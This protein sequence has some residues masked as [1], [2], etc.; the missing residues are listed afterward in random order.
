MN[1]EKFNEIIDEVFSQCKTLLTKKG[2]EY[3]GKEDRL[4][5]FKIA[6]TIKRETPLESLSGMMIKHTTKLYGKI[7]DY[8][9]IISNV[10]EWEEVINDHINYLILLKAVLIDEGDI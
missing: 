3:T 10:D 6:A 1:L 7:G 2:D 8:P 9:G 4:E 5:Q